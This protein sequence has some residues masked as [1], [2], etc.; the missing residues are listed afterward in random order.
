M[1]LSTIVETSKKSSRSNMVR[2]STATKLLLQL[3][4][5]LLLL[6]LLVEVVV[7]VVLSNRQNYPSSPS[8]LVNITP[9]AK[10]DWD[11][12]CSY[13]LTN[14]PRLFDS[15]HPLTTPLSIGGIGGGKCV[16]THAGYLLTS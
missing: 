12:A 4:L 10:I 6:L 3:L 1:R 14:D 5:L 8:R 11:N 15:M 9:T 2:V 13:N 7:V 16:A